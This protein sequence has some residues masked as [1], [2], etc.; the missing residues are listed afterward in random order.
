M[1]HDLIIYT[2]NTNNYDE[3]TWDKGLIEKCKREKI[4][5]IY[6]TDDEKQS[7]PSYVIVKNIKSLSPIRGL[8]SDRM[9]KLLG[10]LYLPPHLHSIYFDARI[11]IRPGLIDEMMCNFSNGY[12]WI[13]FQ[14]RYRKSAISEII[15]ATIYDKMTLYSALETIKEMNKAGYKEG[16]IILSENGCIG[17]KNN[18]YVRNVCDLW[19][20]YTKKLRCRDQPSLIIA[21]TKYK[22]SKLS[23]YLGESMDKQRDL[24]IKKRKTN[25]VTAGKL[26]I[27]CRGLYIWPILWCWN[28]IARVRYK[29]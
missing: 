13:G 10:N 4:P 9:I 2:V 28:S 23:R 14:H 1:I 8:K 7:V 15:V 26:L 27:I 22:S 11:V 21:L 18:T 6:Y 20:Q 24:E 12:D 16:D 3:T 5:I 19:A 29:L 25:T 17:R